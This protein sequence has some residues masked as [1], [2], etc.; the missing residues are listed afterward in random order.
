MNVILSCN[1]KENK[2]ALLS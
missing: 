1:Y 2:P